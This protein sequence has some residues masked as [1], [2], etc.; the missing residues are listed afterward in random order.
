MPSPS[1]H[2]PPTAVT[3]GWDRDHTPVLTVPSGAVIVVEANDCS[4]GQITP[5]GPAPRIRDLDWSR[6]DLISG[7]IYVEGAMPGDVLQV[8]L[9]DLRP[10]SFGWSA[11][12]PG[13]GLLT[14]EFPDEW[15]Y[16]W[17]LRGDRAPY[18]NGITVPIEPMAGFVGVTPAE[19]GVHSPIPPRPLTGGNMDVRQMGPGSTV[20]LPVEVEGALFGTGDPHA[21]Q[22]DGE[23]AGSAIEAPMTITL[24]LTV[25]RDLAI[26]SP[27][28]IVR[29]A[30]ERPSAA[31][32]GYYVTTGI[33]PDLLEACRTAVRQ[34]I[35]RLVRD[36]GLQAMEAY[37]LCSVAMDL[38]ISQVVDIP[39]VTVS[40]FLPNDLFPDP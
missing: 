31:A 39:N 17:D 15:L 36:R 27:E 35:R 40:A 16:I 4:H 20:F 11:N 30:I 3:A 9:I 8:D 28:Y 29:R 18:V 1:F 26:H 13:L 2:L 24:R 34:M 23:V 22:G 12:H 33:G 5:D 38:K 10:G 25:R 32:R 37:M 19:Q 21:A 7:P 14:D 6:M